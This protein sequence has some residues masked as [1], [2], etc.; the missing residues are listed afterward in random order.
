LIPRPE[1]EEMVDW[2]ISNQKFPFDQLKILDIGTGSGCIA[3]SLKRKFRKS[4]SWA[5]DASE[6][7]LQVARKN[8]E[9]LGA[10]IRFLKL[11]ILDEKQWEQLPIFDLVISNP[12]YVPEKDQGAMSPNILKYEPPSALFVSNN[13]PLLF[14]RKI[15]DFGDKHLN[16]NGF[17]Y[18][19]I[20]ERLGKDIMQLFSS[21]G[22][23]CELK[24]D[25]QGKDRM[26]RASR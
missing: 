4:E 11:D 3:I 12:P 5:C 14:Y 20:H 19:E 8:A 18:V 10:D 6:K 16:D 26:V 9:M 7:A 15:T 24:K 2:V 25:M 23:R 21:Q 1:T 17:I 22:Y 13:D